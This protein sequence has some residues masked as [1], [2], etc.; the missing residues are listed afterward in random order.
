MPEDEEEEITFE[1]IRAMPK[2]AKFSAGASS[3]ATHVPRMFLIRVYEFI[4]V[5][6]LLQHLGI[7]LMHFSLTSFSNFRY[8]QQF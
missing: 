4:L 7:L 6:S 1:M 8:F 5:F 2:K 3:G